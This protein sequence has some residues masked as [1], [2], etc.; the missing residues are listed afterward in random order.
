M[1]RGTRN[2]GSTSTSRMTAAATLH[3]LLPF[4][5]AG[6]MEAMATAG[7]VNHVVG[8]IR[9]GGQ[10]NTFQT[11]ATQVG[12][13]QSRKAIYW[14]IIVI[15]LIGRT[16]VS[17][18]RRRTLLNSALSLSLDL[19]KKGTT[20]RTGLIVLAPAVVA[21]NIPRRQ[22]V[23]DR[24]LTVGAAFYVVPQALHE[25]AMGCVRA[26]AIFA[27]STSAIRTFDGMME[28]EQPLLLVSEL[29]FLPIDVRCRGRGLVA[30]A[31]ATGT[32][33]SSPSR[34][35]IGRSAAA[36]LRVL[37]F[38]CSAIL[39]LSLMFVTVL[40]MVNVVGLLQ[41]SDFHAVEI[42]RRHEWDCIHVFKKVTLSRDTTLMALPAST[43]QARA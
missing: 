6:R 12:R 1:A 37:L 31:A 2:D 21:Q 24:A 7:D 18:E 43:V 14:T 42:E 32:V 20:D 13:L 19:V 36:V 33:S 25:T 40:G 17:F 29:F 38:C 15:V 27:A 35:V 22:T 34:G 8:H 41:V 26:N 9:V 3:L 39:L 11:Y 28:Q 30:P 10:N 5:K 23:L 4:S 16:T